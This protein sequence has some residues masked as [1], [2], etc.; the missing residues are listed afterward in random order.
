MHKG[1]G[2]GDGG[3]GI[4]DSV[5]CFED[6]LSSRSLT[7]SLVLLGATDFDSSR[8]K[9]CNLKWV[10]AQTLKWDLAHS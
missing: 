2:E 8:G 5:I 6:P 1:L 10:H 7:R 9:A 3:V 4:L